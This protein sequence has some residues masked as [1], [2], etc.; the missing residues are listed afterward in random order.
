MSNY[1]QTFLFS[2]NLVRNYSLLEP[3]LKYYLH[4]CVCATEIYS[5]LF[6]CFGLSMQHVGSYF[7]DQG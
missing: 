6:I 4:F 2:Q 7:P 3:V 5:I 1:I